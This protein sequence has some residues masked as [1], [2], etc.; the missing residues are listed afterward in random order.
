MILSCL[1]LGLHYFVPGQASG[2]LTTMG[3]TTSGEMES[4]PDWLQDR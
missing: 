1:G 4:Y 2:M 3:G